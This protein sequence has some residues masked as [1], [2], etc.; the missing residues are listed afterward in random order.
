[1]I[2]FLT[3]QIFRERV[4]STSSTHLSR[5]SLVLRNNI[6]KHQAHPSP[7]HDCMQH[8][9]CNDWS[10]QGLLSYSQ[11]GESDGYGGKH[12]GLYLTSWELDLRC[13][14]KSQGTTGGHLLLLCCDLFPPVL[15]YYSAPSG[16]NG[17]Y[18]GVPFCFFWISLCLYL[19][20]DPISGLFIIP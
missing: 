10:I 3:G 13:S 17:I 18:C 7:R 9:K 1:M 4:V 20:F 15:T 16:G 19:I 8:K 5:V 6:V 11:D 12:E 14:R 2:E